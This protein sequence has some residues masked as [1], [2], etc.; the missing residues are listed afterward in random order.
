MFFPHLCKIRDAETYHF[1]YDKFSLLVSFFSVE[2]RRFL[3]MSFTQNVRHLK[4]IN[5]SISDVRLLATSFEWISSIPLNFAQNDA[6]AIFIHLQ[7]LQQQ[8]PKKSH[9]NHEY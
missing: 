8:T 2:K 5:R 7:S 9:I 3:Q 4:D 6:R 1:A